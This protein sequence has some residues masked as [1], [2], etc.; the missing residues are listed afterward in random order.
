[1]E[2]WV[3]TQGN[4]KL[5]KIEYVQYVEGYDPI[6]EYDGFTTNEIWANK[7][8]VELGQYKTKERCLEIIDEIQKLLL[9]AN[10]KEAFMLVDCR[11]DNEFSHIG[12]LVDF[13]RESNFIA[14]DGEDGT[15]FQLIQPSVLVYEMPQE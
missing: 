15:N 14:Y 3:R 1:M 4:D 10:P 12:S 7:E 11:N 13:A 9:S 5:V 6:D 8:E 2:L